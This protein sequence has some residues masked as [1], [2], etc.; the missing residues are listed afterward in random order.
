[1]GVCHCSI[2]THAVYE[3]SSNP[4]SWSFCRSSCCVRDFFFLHISI[5]PHIHL[6][7]CYS[8]LISTK[9]FPI[10][11][12]PFVGIV[13]VEPTMASKDVFYSRYEERKASID[14]A[15]NTTSVRKDTWRSKNEALAYFMKRLP[16]KTWDSRIVQLL[17]VRHHC[18]PA[19][20]II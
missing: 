10:A 18:G 14:F 20:L 8:S 11:N 3:R 4:S 15:V 9:E 5:N 6:I 17:V 19:F 16:W 1:M 2:C 13:L 7:L 12:M